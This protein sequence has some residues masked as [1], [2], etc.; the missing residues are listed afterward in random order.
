MDFEDVSAACPPDDHG[1]DGLDH[2]SCSSAETVELQDQASGEKRTR[3]SGDW[4]RKRHASLSASLGGQLTAEEN[5]Q[6]RHLKVELE[7]PSERRRSTAYATLIG[8]DTRHRWP[9]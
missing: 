2:E 5:D 3:Y 6:C 8:T 1:F 4:L 7:Q 9:F